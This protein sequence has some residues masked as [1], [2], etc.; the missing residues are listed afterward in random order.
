LKNN[1]G[2][3]EILCKENLQHICSTLTVSVSY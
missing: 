2:T 1:L 3:A